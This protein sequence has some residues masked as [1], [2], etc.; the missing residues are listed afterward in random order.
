MLVKGPSGIV[1]MEKSSVKGGLE[2]IYGQVKVKL[3]N[4]N[5]LIFLCEVQ[6]WLVKIKL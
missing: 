6:M 3:R 2:Q 1:V 4:H 5:P